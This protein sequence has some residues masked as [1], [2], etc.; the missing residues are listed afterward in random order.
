MKTLFRSYEADMYS[1]RF[2]DLIQSVQHCNLCPRLHCRRKVFSTA[3]G[4]LASKVLFIAEAPGRLGADKTGIPLSGDRTGNNFEM[5][6]G[7][8][9]WKREDIFITNAI[10]CNPQQENGNNDTPTLEEIENCA[11][12]LEM[13]I[14]LVAPE[15]IV[16]LGA[17]ALNALK[18]IHFH[19]ITLSQSVA[20]PVPWRERIV[21][22]LYHPSPRATMH[23]SQMVQRTDYM[24]LKKLVDPI[25]GLIS[26]KQPSKIPITSKSSEEFL[27]LQKV[28]KTLLSLFPHGKYVSQF[29]ITKLIYLFDLHAKRQ[30]GA[31]C[32][33]S[34]YLRQDYG[35]WPPLLFDALKAMDGDG[36]MIQR[37]NGK[38]FFSNGLIP[39][40]ELELSDEVL[41]LITKI[42]SLYGGK[43]DS[44]LRGI[45]YQTTPMKHILKLEKQGMNMINSP[46]L[47]KNRECQEMDED[48]QCS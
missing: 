43:N 36:V 3:N 46:V 40:T 48:E 31:T 28:A 9:G 41:S 32:A 17:T 24:K 47:Y 11:A 38:Y 12:Y 30:F 10:L 33:S 35:P 1:T 25:K 45:V 20:I 6:L 37:K 44:E 29:K 4:N 19:D 13:T 39:K 23:R 22:S 14:S 7:N 16:P 5:F 26:K 34:I 2:E 27:S 21:F 15:V 8:I 42:Y 18:I